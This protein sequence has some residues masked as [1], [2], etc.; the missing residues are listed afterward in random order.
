VESLG[1]VV[2]YRDPER[3]VCERL[4]RGVG[5]A[6]PAGR[7]REKG[8][9]IERVR[10]GIGPVLVGWLI[11]QGRADALLEF[12]PGAVNRPANPVDR[13]ERGYAARVVQLEVDLDLE[14][15]PVR[16]VR[17]GSVEVPR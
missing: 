15:H 1:D 12:D 14:R 16:Q 8:T 7:R 17:H 11:E 13:L 6:V 5:S 3:Q 4:E 9:L 10:P 2:A